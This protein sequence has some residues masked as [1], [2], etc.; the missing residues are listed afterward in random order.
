MRVDYDH[1]PLSLQ[2]KTKIMQKLLVGTIKKQLP[3][4]FFFH[5]VFSGVLFAGQLSDSNVVKLANVLDNITRTDPSILEALKKYQSVQ[6]ERS[7]AASEYYP[8]IGTSLTTGPERTKGVPTND[9][10]E[11]LLA[12]TAS[13]FARQNL[14]NGGKTAA[15]VKE[16]DARILAAAYDVLTVANRVYLD[17]AEAYINVVKARELL[18]IAKENASTQERIMR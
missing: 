10:E 11:N 18:R 6:A 15:F 4:L 17:C 9:L 8:T 14:Y 13:L 12:T 1:H 2:A 5:L 3:L 16:T 7:I